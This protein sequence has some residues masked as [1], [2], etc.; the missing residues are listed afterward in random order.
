MTRSATC[1]PACTPSSRRRVE[2]PQTAEDLTQEVLLRLLRSPSNHLADPTAWLY[3]VARNVII[4]HYR[5]RHP[6]TPLHSVPAPATDALIDPFADDPDTAR[7]ELARCLRPMI[8]QLPEPYRSAVTAVDLDARHQRVRS[9]A[10]RAQRPRREIPRTARA[11]PTT[12]AAHKLLRCPDRRRRDRDRL[13]GPTGLL[14]LPVAPSLDSSVSLRLRQT[15]RGGGRH[16]AAVAACTWNSRASSPGNF[17]WPGHATANARP[18]LPRRV[19]L[20]HTLCR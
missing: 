3:R 14:S 8:E 13:C 4:D 11:A 9:H 6:T 1:A 2:N 18:G 10:H 16:L 17:V 20:Q 15:A 12:S 5:N 7:R 19:P